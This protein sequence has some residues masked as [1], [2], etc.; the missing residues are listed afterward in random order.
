MSPRR[1][2]ENIIWGFRV[3]TNTV[4]DNCNYSSAP[5]SSYTLTSDC[6]GLMTGEAC[7]QTRS[8]IKQRPAPFC[9][10]SRS[11]GLWHTPLHPHT[12]TL[13]SSQWADTGWSAFTQRRIRT[14]HVALTCEYVLSLLILTFPL[15]CLRRRA[16]RITQSQLRRLTY[17]S[18]L[19][20]WG[21]CWK[22]TDRWRSWMNEPVI[23]R[24]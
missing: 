4:K 17:R 20:G 15:I 10:P 18:F 1:W 13:T 6:R 2:G 16:I 12:H 19:Y 21:V 23:R 14:L 24:L 7:T 5:T 8:H 9:Q 11:A 3:E 22:V